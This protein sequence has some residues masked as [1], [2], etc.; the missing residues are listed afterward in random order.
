MYT[1]V[2]G[3]DDVETHGTQLAE[4]VTALPG[5][6]AEFDVHV[7]HSFEDNPSGASATQVGSVRRF[8]EALDRTGID[9]TVHEDSGEPGEAIRS[10]TTAVNADMILVGGRKRSPAGKALFGSVTQDIILNADR[11]VTV[12]RME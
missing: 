6:P 4:Q 2:V 10:L 12:I 1:I 11:P 8:V 7:L 3:V 9:V 5:D